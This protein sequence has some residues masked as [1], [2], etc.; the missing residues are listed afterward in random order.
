M[1]VLVARL[2]VGQQLHQQAGHQVDRGVQLGHLL[3]QHGHAPVVLGAVQP[4]P[5]H[6][7]L[8]GHVVG[9]VR[10]VLMPEEG[11]R[12]VVHSYPSLL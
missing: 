11:Q 8:A 12:D 1:R 2:G 10:L 4:D 3:E 5:G 7:V 6:G 9:V